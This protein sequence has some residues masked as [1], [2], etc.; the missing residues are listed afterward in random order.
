MEQ[1]GLHLA[2]PPTAGIDPRAVAD[3]LTGLVKLANAVEGEG[4]GE[5]RPLPDW[6]IAD[7]SIGSVNYSVKPA[8]GQEDAGSHR[9]RVVWQ[10]AQQLRTSAGIPTGWTEQAVQV[11]SI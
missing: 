11:F 7:L 8:V 5:D 3:G 9:L 2:G 1:L 4:E 10:G 6:V